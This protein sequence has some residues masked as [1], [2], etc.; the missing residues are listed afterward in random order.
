MELLELFFNTNRQ[1]PIVEFTDPLTKEFR[2][3]RHIKM[4]FSKLNDPRHIYARLPF[5]LTME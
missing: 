4:L 5:T 3:W 1:S 2:Q